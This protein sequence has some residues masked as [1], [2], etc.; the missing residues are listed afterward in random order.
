MPINAPITTADFLVLQYKELDFLINRRQFTGSS[1]LNEI[2]DSE[3]E[4]PEYFDKY[5]DYNNKR[6]VLCDFDQYL[7]DKYRCINPSQ[8][9]ICLIISV[10]SFKTEYYQRILDVMN[11]YENA[12]FDSIG[13]IVSSLVEMRPLPLKDINI[14]P[15]GLDER[16]QRNG[17]LGCR[18][19]GLERIQ[20]FID[21]KTSII[22]IL[23]GMIHED[24][25]S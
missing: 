11:R 8:L 10:E 13:L 17:L 20:F 6:L 22:N 7:M 3:I 1:S 23:S 19:S 18:F 14:N 24:S 2:N 5:T 4:T 25:N 21:I 9:R 15:P 12:H 16:L